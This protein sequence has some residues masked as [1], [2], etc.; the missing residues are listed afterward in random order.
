MPD[1]HATLS[2][3]ASHRWLNCNKSARF[4]KQYADQ[5]TSYASEGTY[6]HEV[7]EIKL[8]QALYK[9]GY[10]A[11][12]PKKR[13]SKKSEFWSASLEEYIDGYVSEVMEHIAGLEAPIVMLEQRLDFSE[14]VPGGFGTGDVVIVSEGMLDVID[15]KYG[16]GVPVNAEENSQL[17]LYGLGAYAAFDI[18]YDIETVRMMIKQPR[19]DNSS[20]YTVDAEYL[21]KWADEEVKPKAELAAKGQG[22]MEA[23]EW[24]RFCKARKDCRKRAEANLALAKYDFAPGPKLTDAEIGD[25]LVKAKELKS[26][27]ED[28]EEYALH[29]AEHN[30]KKWDGWK[31]VE[32][33]SNRKYTDEQAAIDTLFGAGY[34]YGEIMNEKVKG[35]SELEKSLGKKRFTEL[36]GDL[37]FKPPGKPTLAPEDDKR[38][39]L[40]STAAAIEDFKEA[41]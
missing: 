5:E 2:A 10:V 15:L 19:L 27:V 37:V 30:G 13:I 14:W 11:E 23:G 21:L 26:W 31:L 33:R 1:V 6:A 9:A 20:E 34:E 7:A 12:R 17:M 35:I 16:K 40:N 8:G 36:L 18:L 25:I 24:C 41:E 3:S 4:E 38:P 39:E 22:S 29:E 28:I 32:G